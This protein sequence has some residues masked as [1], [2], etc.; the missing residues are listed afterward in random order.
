MRKGS[1]GAFSVHQQLLALAIY[2]ARHK[3]KPEAFTR[4]L[5]ECPPEISRVR[6]NQV[7]KKHHELA[8]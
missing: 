2:L 4:K 3:V 6:T 8:R 1:G 5:K 7:L